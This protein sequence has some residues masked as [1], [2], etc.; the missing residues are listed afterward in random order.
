MAGSKKQLIY[1][2]GG[3]SYLDRDDFLTHLKNQPLYHM[4][5]VGNIEIEKIW[6]DSLPEDLG[7]GWQ[8]I[9]PPMP[10]KQNAWYNNQRPHDAGKRGLIRSVKRPS[11]SCF[12]L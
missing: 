4:P 7:G 11:L 2:G 1:I 9:I 8:V 5:G 10:N 12:L 3:D 6:K